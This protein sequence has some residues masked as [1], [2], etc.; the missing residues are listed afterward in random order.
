[1]TVWRKEIYRVYL[2]KKCTVLK[3]KNRRNTFDTKTMA[4]VSLKTNLDY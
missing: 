4:M 1:M 3:N 2:F